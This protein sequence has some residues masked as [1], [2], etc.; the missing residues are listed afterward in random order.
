MHLQ[1]QLGAWLCQILGTLQEKKSPTGG[2]IQELWNAQLTKSPHKPGVPP[3]PLGEADDKCITLLDICIS[4]FRGGS[5]CRPFSPSAIKVQSVAQ[6]MSFKDKSAENFTF[7]SSKVIIFF[8]LQHGFLDI[9]QSGDSDDAIG[10]IT[11]RYVIEWVLLCPYLYLTNLLKLSE[12]QFKT[13]SR[14]S[15]HLEIYVRLN[16]ANSPGLCI[17]LHWRETE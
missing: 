4:F 16:I 2:E 12:N 9:F 8:C 10:P 15:N 6:I 7:V 1:I 13:T 3:P 14:Q 5:V 11:S 17:C